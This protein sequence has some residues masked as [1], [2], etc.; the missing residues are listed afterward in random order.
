M[1]YL[2]G[3][4][5]IILGISAGGALAQSS[6]CKV[7]DVEQQSYTT[8]DGLVL[9]SVAY[10]S[11]F[12]LSCSTGSNKDL[13]LLADLNGRTLPVS[14]SQDGV[15]YEVSWNAEVAKAP[16]GTFEIGIYEE[17][18]LSA[19]R[20]AQA[21]GSGADAIKPLATVSVSHGGSYRGPLINSEILS[22][23]AVLG[24]W[25]VAYTTKKD[26]TSK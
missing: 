2:I 15:S 9:S 13:T 16:T 4:L 8:W 7:R 10:V 11:T 20:R 12:K 5:A 3:I 23:L 26:L 14:R 17:D 19:L 6:S 18:T 24:L 22:V 1:K 25:Y 21:G